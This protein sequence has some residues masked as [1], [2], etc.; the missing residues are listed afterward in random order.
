[1]GIKAKL[2]LIGGRIACIG[3]YS[4]AIPHRHAVENLEFGDEW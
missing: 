3:T 2:A 1:M 4:V